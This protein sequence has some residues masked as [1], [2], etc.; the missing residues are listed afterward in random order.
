MRRALLGISAGALVLAAPATAHVTVAPAFIAAYD[1]QKLVFAAPN[2]RDT[3][4]TGFSVTVPEGFEIVDAGHQTDWHPVVLGSKVTWSGGSLPAGE[5][6]TF[7]L[8]LKGPA[9]PGAVQ[10][11]GDQLYASGDVVHWPVAFTV[12]LGT[13][14]SEHLGLAAIVAGGG[15]VF[16]V[17]FVVVAWRRRATI[18]REK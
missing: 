2:E 18:M 15:L 3:P 17:L 1:T 16:T 14:P 7:T 13:K 4:M 8:A 10:L 6:A 11:S 12:V 9:S 5:E